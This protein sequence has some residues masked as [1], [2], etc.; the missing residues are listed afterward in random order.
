MPIAKEQLKI[1]F[2]IAAN[3]GN[4]VSQDAVDTYGWGD[5]VDSGK[6]VVATEDDERD[7]LAT[8]TAADANAKKAR[9]S[10]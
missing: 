1:G 2:T 10:K 9:N 8:A 5:K 7:M 6:D 3:P 4:Y